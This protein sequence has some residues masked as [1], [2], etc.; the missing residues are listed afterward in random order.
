MS[1]GSRNTT[2]SRGIRGACE[3]CVHAH[4][5]ARQML[6]AGAERGDSTMRYVW[7]G[8]ALFSL[9][10]CSSGPSVADMERQARNSED[11]LR[12]SCRQWD[13]RAKAGVPSDASTTAA[14]CWADLRQE[15][16]LHAQQ[17]ADLHA[18][19]MRSIMNDPPPPTPSFA[20]PHS[21]YVLPSSAPTAPTANPIPNLEGSY[22]YDRRP[23]QVWG[24]TPCGQFV[25]PAMQEL[26]VNSTEPRLPEGCR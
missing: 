16:E 9:A 13:E 12:A 25:P 5:S 4:S 15:Q 19:A 20:V 8:I 1:G 21:A 23:A 6:G 22:Q 11:S 24:Q 2:P 18:F 26:P 14:Q 7:L 17:R 10:G 3:P